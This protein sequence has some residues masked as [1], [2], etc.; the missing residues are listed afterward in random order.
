M[1][2]QIEVDYK[3]TIERHG[4]HRGVSYLISQ[5]SFR[6]E[7]DLYLGP[8]IWCTYVLLVPEKYEELKSRLSG[9]P[10]NGDITFQRKISEEHIDC[11][12]ELKAKWDSS[13]FKIGDDFAHSWDRGLW[14]LDEW[15]SM[16]AHIKRVIDYLLDGP[17]ADE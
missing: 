14:G 5:H 17:K 4:N 10:W 11:S 16:E 13:Y 3:T 9:A 2:L 15:V 8:C 1:K 6:D 7:D 12:P